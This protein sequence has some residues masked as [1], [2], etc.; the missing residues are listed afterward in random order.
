MCHESSGVALT[1]SIGIG[2]G[3]V[4]LEDFDEADLIFVI[5]QNPGTNHPRMLSVLQQAARRGCQI[6]T[7]NPILERGLEK[8]IHPQEALQMLTGTS[9]SISTHYFQPMIGGDLA[10]LQGLIK[11]VL[12]A[13][14]TQKNVL[15]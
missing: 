15:E 10:L 9:S 6:V 13:E 1:E 7:F 14:E 5:G 11:A 2:K 8:F 4:Q 3:T 12:A